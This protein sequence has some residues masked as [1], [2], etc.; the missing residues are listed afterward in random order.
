V[1][2]AVI[3]TEISETKTLSKNDKSAVVGLIS[4]LQPYFKEI[5]V[6]SDQPAVYLPY[7]KDTARILTPFYKGMDPLSSLHAALSLA[8]SDDVWI[9]HEAF[10]FPGINTFKEIKTLKENS[11][12]QCAVYDKKNPNLLYSIFDK[13]VLHIL[14]EAINTNSNRIADFFN[15]IDCTY[16][17]LQKKKSLQT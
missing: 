4:E 17:P 5:I 7:V 15:H 11:N 10:P 13:R 3:L 12:S 14:D 2:A 9:L 6:V 1:T 16:F 8:I